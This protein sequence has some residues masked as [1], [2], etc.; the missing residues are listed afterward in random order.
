MR[1]ARNAARAYCDKQCVL[2]EENLNVGSIPSSTTLM[3][4]PLDVLP[5]QVM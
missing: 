2:Y 5:Q 3:E 4:N 1:G